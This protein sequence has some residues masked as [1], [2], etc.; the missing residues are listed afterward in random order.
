MPINAP[1]EYFKA[2]KKFKSAKT[3]EEKIEALEEML[4]FLPTHKGT[5]NLRAQ[6]RKRLAKLRK[7]R[8][9]KISPK[10]KFSIKKEGAGQVCLIGLTNSGKS[11]LLKKLTGVDV[12]IA[13]YPYTT[14]K[15]VVGMMEYEDVQIQL[16]EIPS[17]F[18]KDVMSIVRNCDSIVFVLDGTKDL[19]KQKEELMKVMEENKIRINEEPKDVKIEKRSYGGIEIRGEKNIKG[20]IEEVK[21]ILRASGY[22]NCLLVVNEEVTVEDIMN[23]LDRSLVYK[24]A[25]FV[26]SKIP[27]NLDEIKRE[28]W[29]TLGLIRVYTKPRMGEVE[30][31]PLTL[32]IGST[33]KDMIEKIGKKDWVKMFKFAKVWGN[34]V[35]HG[36]G[37][38]GLDH[39]LE[40]GDIVEIYT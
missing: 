38:V 17:T 9:V 27:T 3:K 23:A 30:K 1:I 32:P 11:T 21:E 25:I 36:V 28:I 13:S 8:E 37:K 4:R 31:K 22:D 26:V 16:V 6:L 29:Y 15:P 24:N 12:E 35:K 10:P 7:K 2:E 40:D 14:K 5:E 39:V 33:V 19:I 18:S 34:S 20:S